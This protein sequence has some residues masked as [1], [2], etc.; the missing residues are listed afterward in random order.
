MRVGRALSVVTVGGYVLI[1]L[2][3]RDVSGRK[4]SRRVVSGAQGVCERL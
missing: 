4:A 3:K 1:V 2:Q